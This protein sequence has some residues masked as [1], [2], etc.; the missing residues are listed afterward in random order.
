MES[1]LKFA[2]CIVNTFDRVW[3]TI[4]KIKICN[5]TQY[6]VLSF[7]LK[8]GRRCFHLLCLW[9]SLGSCY[10]A[11]VNLCW[12]ALKASYWVNSLI[13]NSL[14][15]PSQD[16]EKKRNSLHA[17]QAGEQYWL[18]ESRLYPRWAPLADCK[19]VGK[20]TPSVFL[21]AYWA[22]LIAV[23]NLLECQMDRP[24]GL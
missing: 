23:N 10:K 18:S 14:S 21:W 5:E 1:W 2:L 24:Y 4:P 12:P 8:H 3:T 6:S 15:S 16:K 19:I 20:R 9:M 13:T 17:C 7:A 11:F 22:K